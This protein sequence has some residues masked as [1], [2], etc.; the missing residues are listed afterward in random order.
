MAKDA[1]LSLTDRIVQQT[2]KVTMPLAKFSQLKSISSIVNGLIAVMPVIMIG[3]VFMILYV[4]GSPSIGTMGHALVPF[5]TPWAAKFAW[6]NSLTMGFMGLYAALTISQSYGEVLKVDEKGASLI[7]VGTFIIFNIAGLDKSG[8]IDFTSF[9]ASGLFIAIITSLVSIR[10]YWFFLKYNITIH[11]PDS[12]PPNV[13]NAFAAIFPYLTA[14]G[15]AWFVRTICNFNALVW[16]NSILEPIVGHSQNVWSAMFIAFVVLLLW[17]VGMHGDNMFLSLFTPFGMTWI[18]ENAKALANGTSSEHLP[19]ML[20]AVGQSGLLR[21]TI[22]TAAAW[23]VIFLMI[24]SK[25]KFLKTLGWTTIWPGIFTIVEPVIFG[26]PLA[27]NP[28]LLIP[29]VL[30]G[31]ISTGVNYLIMAT[32]YFGKFFALIPWA[33][34][35]FLLGPLGTGDWK[36][37]FIPVISF[38]IGLVIYLPFWPQFV[39]SLDE[40]EK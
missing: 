7:G 9:S 30:S 5:L 2:N 31:T 39:K 12:V 40:S 19:N 34:P 20:A 11:M 8:G 35:P 33:T 13:G 10:I 37:A 28:Y 23:P 4:L 36:T 32:P 14:F 15:L 18:S 17:S 22:W 21:M 38:F 3:S 16:L 25:N 29:F 6:M 26:L 24:I 1:K 27:L